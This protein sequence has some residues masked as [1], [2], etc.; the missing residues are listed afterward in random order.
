MKQTCT[1]YMMGNWIVNSRELIIKREDFKRKC[2]SFNH[3][4]KTTR[5]MYEQI[6]RLQ[7]IAIS[8]FFSDSSLHTT[9][10]I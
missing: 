6:V 7:V 4:T 9:I 3:T 5:Y 8:S 2:Q 10:K 1:N